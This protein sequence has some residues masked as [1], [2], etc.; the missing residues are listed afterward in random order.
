MLTL[1]KKNFIDLIQ[2]H[3]PLEEHGAI[4]S[5]YCP[6]C[7]DDEETFLA[8]PD[9]Q[10]W[11]CFACQ[12]KGNINQF[13]EQAEHLSVQEAKQFINY[14]VNHSLENKEILN[15]VIENSNSEEKNTRA[16]E[17][18][19]SDTEIF[20]EETAVSEVDINR[21]ETKEELNIPEPEIATSEPEIAISEPEIIVSEPEITLS[22]DNNIDDIKKLLG[23]FHECTGCQGIAII[24]T[25]DNELI[26]SSI[27]DFDNKDIQA[28]NAFV[29]STLKLT[30]DILGDFDNKSTKLTFRMN[31]VIKSEQKKLIWVP[32]LSKEHHKYTL[33]MLLD[34]KTSEKMLLIKLKNRLATVDM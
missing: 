21:Y 7:F 20:E 31:V 1:T 6:F 32:M 18:A 2:T 27:D 13:I 14:F 26:G 9:E 17:V 19:V 22:E 28:L 29:I 16:L 10:R 24:H 4:S 25:S 11:N 12:K 5:G 34:D 33:L 3:V 30:T 15:K 8:Y 23:S